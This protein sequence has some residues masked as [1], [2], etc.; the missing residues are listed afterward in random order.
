MK[1]LIL[2]LAVSTLFFSCEKENP[3]PNQPIQPTQPTTPPNSNI[4]DST[5]VYGTWWVSQ[6]I[7]ENGSV[8]SISSSLYYEFKE[9]LIPNAD[10]DWRLFTLDWGSEVEVESG[11]GNVYSDRI[12]MVDPMFGNNDY[13]ILELSDTTLTFK[14]PIGLKPTYYCVR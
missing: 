14:S 4:G 13:E 6:K 9:P 12:Q 3:Q 2:I 10:M 5:L 8:S 1:N 7:N 11:T